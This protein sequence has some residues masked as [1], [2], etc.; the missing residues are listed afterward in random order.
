MRPK[1]EGTTGRGLDGDREQIRANLV[2]F[3]EHLGLSQQKL[4][5]RAGIPVDNLRRYEQ[6]QRS[7]DAVNLRAL[8]GAL[9]HLVDH[10]FLAE[11]PAAD[12]SLIPRWT[13]RVVPGMEVDEDLDRKVREFIAGVN[14]EQIERLRRRKR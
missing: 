4:A 10:F 6:G 7:I 2:R 12:E 3:R 14:R 9:G 8:A 11:P 13:A 5:D 1:A